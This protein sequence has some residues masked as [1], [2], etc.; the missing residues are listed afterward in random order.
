MADVDND[1]SSSEIDVLFDRMELDHFG[2]TSQ[3]ELL[4]GVVYKKY[5]SIPKEERIEAIKKVAPKFLAEKKNGI[6]LLQNMYQIMKADGEIK[7]SE[8]TFF[9]AFEQ[10]VNEQG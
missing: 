1:L 5:I 4:V 6:Q 9:E 7:E 10:I 8:K 3:N 2:S